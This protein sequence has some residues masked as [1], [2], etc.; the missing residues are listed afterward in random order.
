[1][2]MR[3]MYTEIGTEDNLKEIATQV[4][5]MAIDVVMI[6]FNYFFFVLSAIKRINNTLNRLG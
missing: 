2:T 5:A 1:M 6:Q 3:V 4:E